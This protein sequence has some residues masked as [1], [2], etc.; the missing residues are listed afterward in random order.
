VV[1]FFDP[2]DPS[3]GEA[4]RLLAHELSRGRYSEQSSLIDRVA[5][6]LASLWH[7]YLDV[8]VGGGAPLVLLVVVAVLVVVLLVWILPKVRRERRGPGATGV[9]DDPAATPADY[10][11]RAARALEEGRLDDALL[12]TFRALTAEAI[13]RTLL[14]DAPGQTAHEIS[15]ALGPSFPDRRAALGVAADRFDAVRYGNARAS[16]A[17]VDEMAELDRALA[18]T[19]PHLQHTTPLA[20][21]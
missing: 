21:T 15:I 20:H 16:R 13:D 12:D 8:S 14:D 7:R 1:P 11:A 6:W 19:R 3:S 5:Q 17:E 18:L 2:V 9:I 10:R 4:R